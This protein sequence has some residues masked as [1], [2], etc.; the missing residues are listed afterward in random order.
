MS[1]QK[2]TVY[3]RKENLIIDFLR[4]FLAH[5]NDTS[6]L[7]LYPANANVLMPLIAKIKTINGFAR[8][9]KLTASSTL[10]SIIPIVRDF[11]KIN[12]HNESILHD[13]VTIMSKLHNLID[14]Y[15]IDELVDARAI[16][17][18][19]M[20][21]KFPNYDDVCKLGEAWGGMG[22]Q[23]SHIWQKSHEL[24]ARLLD[25]KSKSAVIVAEKELLKFKAVYKHAMFTT[26]VEFQ[27]MPKDIMVEIALY[28][29][30]VHRYKQE[31]TFKL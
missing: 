3:F 15:G 27:A 1:R 21:D 12:T 16:I 31:F 9:C 7:L 25:S 17:L 4:E 8:S 23:S 19:T 18:K 30:D 24:E 22:V 11:V 10:E 28:S 14:T 6:Q 2:K 13:R 5:M 26:I 29:G 20:V